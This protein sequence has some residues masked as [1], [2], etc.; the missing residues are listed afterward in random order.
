M[1]GEDDRMRRPGGSPLRRSLRAGQLG[2]EEGALAYRSAYQVSR[3]EVCWCAPACA[4]RP[5]KAKPGAG[6]G[7]AGAR[8]GAAALIYESLNS[9]AGGLGV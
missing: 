1:V 9:A 7:P 3:F 5:L 6:V 4:G 8:S 2:G